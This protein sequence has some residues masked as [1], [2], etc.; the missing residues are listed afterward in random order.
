VRR[1]L[2][3]RSVVLDKVL[4]GEDSQQL[5][6]V[7]DT[8]EE[9]QSQVEEAAALQNDNIGCGCRKDRPKMEE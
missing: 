2:D 6:V 1:Q 3:C 4:A 9:E 8:T 5:F 7:E